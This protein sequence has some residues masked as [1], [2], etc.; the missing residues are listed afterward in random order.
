MTR[1]GRAPG[2]TLTATTQD[3]RASGRPHRVHFRRDSRRLPRGAF[4]NRF[5]Y[6]RVEV[7]DRIPSCPAAQCMARQVG[8]FPCLGRSRRYLYR[9]VRPSAARG[10]VCPRAYSGS[11]YFSLSRRLDEPGCRVEHCEVLV[12][13][14]P[15]SLLRSPRRGHCGASTTQ[16][17]TRADRDE[18]WFALARRTA[19]LRLPDPRLGRSRRGLTSPRPPSV[20]S[21]S[22]T[23]SPMTFATPP[24]EAPGVG[25]QRCWPGPPSAG[26]RCIV[27]IARQ[28]SS[29]SWW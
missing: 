5:S 2:R 13:I 11:R 10:L 16:A 28:R 14:L 8:V 25:A 9:P 22:Q 6:V 27:S 17:W 29:P 19:P 21:I 23:R 4:V 26:R 15:P 3:L 7:T 12:A 18:D 1:P 24:L 20:F